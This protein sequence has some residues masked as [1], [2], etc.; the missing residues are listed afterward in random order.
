[1]EHVN[2]RDFDHAGLFARRAG[3][4]LLALGLVVAALGIVGTARE[5][6][7]GDFTCKLL[8]PSEFRCKF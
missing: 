1:M 4:L 3:M 8:S 5:A 7:A 6:K 2:V